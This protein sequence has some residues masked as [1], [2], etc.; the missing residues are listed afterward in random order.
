MSLGQSLY[1][2]SL[3]GGL[4]GLTS[5]A[6]TSLVFSLFTFQAPTW[7]PD[8]VAVPVLGALIGGLTVYFADKWSG[9]VILPRWVVTGTVVGLLS[10]FAAG[11]AQIPLTMHLSARAPEV[12]RILAWMLAGSFI[13]MGLGLRWVSV[14]R[15]RVAHA[16]VGGLI[17][18]ALGGT[19]FVALGN[20]IPDLSQALG[21]MLTGLGISAG[22]ALAPL[23]TRDGVL[24]FVSS[25]DA[26]AQSKFARPQKQWEIHDG[27]SF[28]IGSQPPNFSSTAYRPEVEIFVPDATVARKHARF[29]AREGRFY[30]ARHPEIAGASGLAAYALRVGGRTVTDSVELHDADDIVIGRTA[31]VFL[32]KRKPAKKARQ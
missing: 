11:C 14:N 12:A 28:V 29:S 9:G 2:L 19:V 20:H 18:G 3:V 13:G 24:Q 27:D 16:M 4:A 30:L 22:I 6:L 23:L 17:G 26:R 32:A 25:G 1:F 15:L 7:V 21:Y 8:L 10:G 5:W 31:L